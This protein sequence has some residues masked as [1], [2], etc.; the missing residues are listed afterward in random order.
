METKTQQELKE[1]YG[2]ANQTFPVFTDW[3]KNVLAD[4]RWRVDKQ[5]QERERIK[6]QIQRMQ[7]EI[8]ALK[9]SVKEPLPKRP[10]ADEMTYNYAK[11][12]TKNKAEEEGWNWVEPEEDNLK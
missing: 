5:K 4:W 8:I 3:R 11:T 2:T 12:D 7:D 9:L 6:R 1:K 10:H